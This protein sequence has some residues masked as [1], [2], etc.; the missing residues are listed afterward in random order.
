[1]NDF[2]FRGS[3]AEYDPD[4]AALIELEALRQARKLIL[5]PS[6]STI[7]AA[8]REAVGSVFHNLYAEGYPPKHW[9]RKS[10]EDLLDIDLRLAELRRNGGERYYQGAEIVDILESVARRRTA[11]RFA[12]EQV[13]A[14]KLYVNVQPLSGAPAN[15]AVYTALINVG[16]TIL[17][18]DLLHGGHLTHGS[19]VARSGL[20]YNAIGYSVDPDSEKLDYEH[21]LSL[22]KAHHPK[23]IIGGYTSYPWAPDWKKLR[24]IADEVGAYLLADVSHFAGLIIAGVYPS[25]IGIADVTMFTTHKTLGGPRGAVLITHKAAIAKKL[26]RGV[27][28]GEQGGPHVNSIAGL[29]LA[30]QLADTAQFTALQQQTVYNARRMA[31]KLTERGIRVVYGGTDTHMLLIDV[32]AVVGQDGSKLSGD[33][34]ARMLDVAGIVANRNTIPGDRSPFRAT[35]VRFGTPWITQ[36][37]FREAEVDRLSDII[38]DLVL[39]TE[40]FSYQKSFRGKDLRAKVDGAVLFDAQQR[41]HQLATEA[42][43]DYEIPSLAAYHRMSDAAAE[44]F[45]VLPDDDPSEKW[46]TIEVKGARAGQFLDVVTTNDV[47]ILAYGDWQSTWLLDPSGDVLSQA[48]IERLTED[49]YL[50]HVARNV[51]A[52]S[53]WLISFSDGYT[54]VDPT[55]VY[56]K[57][58]GYVSISP[59][60]DAV[61][62]QRFEGLKL[63]DIPQEDNGFNKRKAYFIGCHGEKLTAENLP[64]LPDFTWKESEPE[65]LLTTK[66]HALHQS[67]GAKMVPFA[68]YDMPVWYSSVREEHLAVRQQAGIFDVTHMGVFEFS[69]LGAE[70]FLNAVTTNDVTKLK[71]GGAHYSYLLGVDGIPIDDI[72][73]YRLAAERFMVVVN[74]SNNDKDWAW[75]QAVQAGK[76]NIDPSRPWVTAPGRENL[77]IRDLRDEANGADCRVD[78]A[79]QGPTSRDILLS[80]DSSAEDLAA[81]KSLSWSAIVHVNLAGFDLWV[82]RTGYTGE[83]VAFELF[84][85]PDQAADLFHTLVEAG[86]VPCGLASRDSLR[87]EAGLPLYGHELAGDY[88]MN[89]ADAGFG[90]Y[91]KLWKPFFI[92]KAAFV[93]HEAERDQICTRFR[94]DQKGGRPAHAGDPVMDRRGRVVGVVTSCSIDTEGYQTGQA[95][96]KDEHSKSG[97]QLFIYSSAGRAKAGKAPGELQ[98][99]DRTTIPEAVTV[100]THFPQ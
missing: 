58:P 75:L 1:M 54:S 6:E 65:E 20:Q 11:E 78:V 67:Y 97:T 40:P 30:M 82:S 95:L 33:M 43:I 73:V 10:L 80:L 85:H 3:I 19:P 72:F 52:I 21:I 27:F 66:L 45:R 79:L 44:H 35:G 68:G 22:A 36:R 9:R 69:G 29:A 100:L 15:S 83:R 57:V 86:A 89:P 61:A 32:G 13:S 12:T 31:A 93:A 14:D 28:P 71:P 91:V 88:N 96:L 70:L 94:I 51:D 24:A 59:L 49:V 63:T 34:A 8:I 48:V 47:W 50:L 90:S 81:I 92:G 37:G 2:L 76:V 38:A 99:G 77:T 60:P 62:I 64:A 17:G 18:M 23:V 98:V 53:Q 25:P 42:G 74:A 5:V 16:D 39:G 4:L 26:D 46:H 7:P 87:I 55:D 84:V 56:A 41:V